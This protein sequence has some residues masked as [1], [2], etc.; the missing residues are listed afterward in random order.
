[1]RA[2]RALIPPQA[3]EG[4]SDASR[5]NM[6]EGSGHEIPVGEWM[7]RASRGST[8]AQL[9]DAFERAFGAMWKRAVVTLGEITLSAIIDRV[10]YDA[11]EKHSFIRLVNVDANGLRCTDLEAHASEIAPDELAAG[12][13]FVMVQ[14]LTVLGSL[15]AEILT[16]A[17]HAELSR[18]ASDPE[19][20][21][22]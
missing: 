9:V 12:I 4:C 16:P 13:R 3:D 19:V 22:S 20:S 5:E 21:Q 11:T 1:M 6:S 8:P 18:A 7:Q 2:G 15:T 14:F 17:L 10:L